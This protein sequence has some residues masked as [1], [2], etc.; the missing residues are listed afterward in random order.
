MSIFKGMF[1]LVAASAFA[2]TASLAHAQAAPTVSCE[3]AKS[4][5]TVARKAAEQSA[6]NTNETCQDAC[7][8]DATCRSACLTVKAAVVG[9]AGLLGTAATA[10]ANCIAT[11]CTNPKACEEQAE[12]TRHD[13]DE[14]ARD[15]AS[16]S[17]RN[18]PTNAPTYL[19]AKNTQLATCGA[20]EATTRATVCAIGVDCNKL[21]GEN[22]HQYSETNRDAEKICRG[23]CASGDTACRATCEAARDTA[24]ANNLATEKA[25]VNNCLA[26]PVC[27]PTTASMAACAPPLSVGAS[28]TLTNAAGTISESG[29]CTSSPSYCQVTTCTPPPAVCPCAADFSNIPATRATWDPAVTGLPAQLVTSGT[30]CLL[31][32]VALTDLTQI[33][34]D[35]ASLLCYSSVSPGTVNTLRPIPDKSGYNAC[36]TLINNY[37]STLQANGVPATANGLCTPAP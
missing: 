18:D 10:Y 15:T 29:T 8:A 21:C 35:A 4:A 12:D 28:C 11:A 1:L 14:G 6:R 17:I 5:C 9:A 30:S 33:S 20:A 26:Q 25:C 36:V 23:N 27:G 2:I 37:F 7:G 31:E 34:A 24:V 13:C 16:T 19:S 22:E 3:D 32:S